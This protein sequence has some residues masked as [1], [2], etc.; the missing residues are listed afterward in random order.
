M[1]NDFEIVKSYKEAKFKQ[2]QIG[3]L[4]EL[5]NCTNG[6]IIKVLLDNGFEKTDRFPYPTPKKII[7]KHNI[8][9]ENK[10]EIS[11]KVETN[12]DKVSENHKVEI[13]P[14]NEVGVIKIKR[15]ITANKDI[16]NNDI[17]SR[18]PRNNTKI[19]DIITESELRTRYV[20]NNESAA[21]I[22]SFLGINV[23]TLNAHINKLGI[24]KKVSTKSVTN[25]SIQEKIKQLKSEAEKHMSL[26]KELLKKAEVLEQANKILSEK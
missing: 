7:E 17:K 18:S 26:A 11:T 25:P 16:L 23:H 4:A 19:S 22:A 2:K 1:Y 20:D 21:S 9:K 10:E 13:F 24:H 8:L 5:N 14:E 3:I 6:D 15:K 12:T